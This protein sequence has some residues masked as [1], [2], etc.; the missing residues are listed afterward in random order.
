MKLT[1]S[2]TDHLINKHYIDSTDRDIYI[3]GFGNISYTVWSTSLLLLLGL[4]VKQ[5]PAA[6]II[7]AV[8]YTL[9]PIGGGYHANTHFRCLMTM[10]IGLLAGLS[11]IVIKK[12]FV[13]LW[14][15]LAISFC[16]LLCFPVV[17]HPNKAFL[18]SE[19]KSLARKSYLTTIVLFGIIILINIFRQS[20]LYAFSAAFLLSAI[21][22]IVGKFV[23]AHRRI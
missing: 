4:V 6:C 7:I 14:I 11:F 21:S 12:Q 16:A 20:M 13:C 18:A 15:I 2:L 1:E 17:F 3:Y 10:I 22:R 9:Q 8:F 19:Q 5:L 23:Y